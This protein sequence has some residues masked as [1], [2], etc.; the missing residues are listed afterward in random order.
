M[1]R[2]APAH[3]SGGRPGPHLPLHRMKGWLMTVRLDIAPGT[4]S[5]FPP[6]LWGRGR[7]GGGRARANGAP[8]TATP[9]PDPSPHGTGVRSHGGTPSPDGVE[10][11]GEGDRSWREAI[12]PHPP[13]VGGR[14]LPMGE[15]KSDRGTA[16]PL[17]F[18]TLHE[19]LP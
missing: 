15:V 7:E 4:A 12:S 1:G 10:G 18:P 5:R 19:A 6:P 8:S 17:P 9:T 3:R 2:R 11:W 13:A 14:P 16:P